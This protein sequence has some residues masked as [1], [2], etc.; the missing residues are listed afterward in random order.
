MKDLRV[1]R[2]MSSVSHIPSRWSDHLICIWSEDDACRSA[3]DHSREHLHSTGSQPGAWA[4]ITDL[5]L[6]AERLPNDPT[7]LGF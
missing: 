2:L 5:A 1:R 6:V 7:A 3:N 4:R